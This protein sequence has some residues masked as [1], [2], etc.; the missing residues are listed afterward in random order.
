MEIDPVPS[1]TKEQ[2]GRRKAKPSTMKLPQ[3]G[4][5]SSFVP[6]TGCRNGR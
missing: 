2:V 3:L 5:Y 4:S 1:K 6:A